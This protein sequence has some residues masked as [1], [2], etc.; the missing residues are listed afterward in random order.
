MHDGCREIITT[1][2]YCQP[3]ERLCGLEFCRQA[4]QREMFLF[5]LEITKK[6]SNIGKGIFS[7]SF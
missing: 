5:F 6:N 7:F 3:N 2:R 1:K 4:N